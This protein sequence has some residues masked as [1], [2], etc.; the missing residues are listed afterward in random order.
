MDCHP[1]S[2]IPAASS[3]GYDLSLW[4]GDMPLHEVPFESRVAAGSVFL[5]RRAD[6]DL[7]DATH[8]S[9]FRGKYRTVQVQWRFVLKRPLRGP[10]F[11]GIESSAP[12][13]AEDDSFPTDTKG[14]VRLLRSFHEPSDIHLS[15]PIEDRA[16][17]K[18]G[19]WSVGVHTRNVTAG[20]VATPSGE[21]PPS[22][23][24]PLAGGASLPHWSDL[25]IGP[26][27][28]FCWFTQ[29]VDLTDLKLCNLPDHGSFAMP[30]HTVRLVLY[31][32][33]EPPLVSTDSAAAA[34]AEPE[35]DPEEE[36]PGRPHE[37]PDGDPLPSSPDR[38]Y[39]FSCVI[40]RQKATLGI[41]P[42]A[43]DFHNLKVKKQPKTSTT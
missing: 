29:F 27:Y 35:E 7:D 16:W 41:M 23:E 20:F 8:R 12:C 42:T 21:V 22:L 17:S 37:A 28:S 24:T 11:L 39:A 18:H 43:E 34:S 2:P 3:I 5:A 14:L 31:E 10:L 33:T 15:F 4:R 9:F 13:Q 6:K 1:D 40:S 36:D 30:A 19:D 26:T 25:V 32:S 38:T